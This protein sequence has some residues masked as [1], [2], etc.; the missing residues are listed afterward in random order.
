M[1]ILSAKA[2]KEWDQYTI[3]NQG[4]SSLDLMERAS[5]KVVDWICENPVAEKFSFAIFCGKGNNGG[6][7][8]YYLGGN[9]DAGGGGGGAGFAGLDATLSN[10]GN[11]GDGLAYSISGFSTYYAGGGGGSSNNQS[12]PPPLYPG[13]G[14]LGGGGKGGIQGTTLLGTDGVDGLGAG[15]GAGVGS[16]GGN[17]GAGGDGIVIVRYLT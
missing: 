6:D 9:H 2:I 13:E 14:G 4:I 12:A 11:G 1:K 10:A 3:K 5:S 16:S 15:G 17:S 8:N 7:G